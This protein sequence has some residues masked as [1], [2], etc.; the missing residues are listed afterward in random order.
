MAN[1]GLIGSLPEADC[2]LYQQQVQTEA[3][4]VIVSWTAVIPAGPSL[5]SGCSKG[6]AIEQAIVVHTII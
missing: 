1:T 3:V 6:H 5:H 2:A 4:P